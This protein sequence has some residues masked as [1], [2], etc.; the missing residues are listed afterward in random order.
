MWKLQR[1]SHH[2]T[3]NVKTFDRTTQKTK[4]MSNTDPTKIQGVFAPCKQLLLLIRHPP[5]YTRCEN[6]NCEFQTLILLIN[7]VSAEALSTEEMILSGT[8]SPPTDVSI[9]IQAWISNLGPATLSFILVNYK[10]LSISDFY[11]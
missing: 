9:V 2:G 1:T 5:C 3:Q 7:H 8:R 10:H 6:R 11:E 4:M